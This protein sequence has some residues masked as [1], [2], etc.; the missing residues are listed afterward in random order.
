MSEAAQRIVEGL[1]GAKVVSAAVSE[2][3][4]LNA[5]VVSLD[6]GQ[7]SEAEATAWVD[8]L[9]QTV[10]PRE[11]LEY[12]WVTP[13]ELA[14]PPP[15]N[16]QTGRGETHVK[17]PATDVLSYAALRPM[18]TMRRFEGVWRPTSSVDQTSALVNWLQ[19]HLI[20]Q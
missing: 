20:S 7:L 19:Q 12:A 14:V 5:R 6:L 16:E 9:S 2:Q 4:L 3:L 17:L 10:R 8:E 13:S 15:N 18:R 1:Y 11:I